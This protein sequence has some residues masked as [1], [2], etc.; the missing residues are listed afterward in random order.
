MTP[1]GNEQDHTGP[2]IADRVRRDVNTLPN[3]VARRAEK[4]EHPLAWA[5]DADVFNTQAPALRSASGVTMSIQ[6][7]HRVRVTTPATGTA[8][9][10]VNHVPVCCT[11][12]YTSALNTK[13]RAN[14]IRSGSR[15]RSAHPTMTLPLTRSA[16]KSST[17]RLNPASSTIFG[18][19]SAVPTGIRSWQG[20]LALSQATRAERKRQCSGLGGADDEGSDLGGDIGLTELLADRRG[21]RLG[22]FH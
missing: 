13:A 5:C 1:A 15:D 3:A 12:A 7:A 10:H 17:R 9:N 18:T 21:G 22:G 8:P 2:V 6:S 16:L 4:V 14:R 20:C 11:N 19:W